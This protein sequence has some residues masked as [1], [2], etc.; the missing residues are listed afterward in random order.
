MEDLKSHFGNKYFCEQT[1]NLLMSYV[2]K[3][4]HVTLLKAQ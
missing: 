3:V 1:E 2:F 4:S